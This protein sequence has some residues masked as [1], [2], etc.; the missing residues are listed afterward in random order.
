MLGNINI[1][2]GEAFAKS[3]SDMSCGKTH[4]AQISSKDFERKQFE[5]KPL[6]EF[7]F[8]ENFPNCC[9][10]HK[11]IYNIGVEKYNSFPNCCED[12]KKLNQVSWF[13]KN[14]YSYIPFKLV[15][16]LTYTWNCI[17]KCLD[18]ENWFKEI[19]DYIDYTVKSYGQFP[20]GY[21]APLG[22]DLYLHN[23]EQNINNEVE[24]PTDKKNKLVDFIKKYF[25][26]VVS[27]EQTD[28]NLLISTYKDWLKIFPFQISFL[29]HLKPAFE[30]QIP[31]LKGQG[32]TN[33]YTGLTAFNLKTKRDLIEFLISVTNSILQEI[34]TCSLFEKGILD[35]TENLKIELLVAERKTK[36]QNLNLENWKERKDYIRLLKKWFKGE[37][38]FLKEIT[39]LIKD[40]SEGA[41]IKNLVDG[42]RRLQH[43]DVNASCIVNVRENKPDK[44]T[45]F[46]YWFIDFL[47]GRYPEAII[48]AEEEKGVG[49]IDLKIVNKILGT[50]I[51]EFKGWWNQSKYNTVE[52]ICN[53][54]TEFEKVG[55]IF[56][57]N[58][59]KNKDIT[60]DYKKMIISN[61]INYIPNSFE[62]HKFKILTSI[63]LHQNTYTI[64]KRKLSIISYLMFTSKYC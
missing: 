45:S 25:S 18:N 48:T 21:G 58:H 3:L 35:E 63:I 24:I 64:Q 22:L 27:I 39:P 16:T 33:I 15:S 1:I 5:T 28:I 62:E 31:I 2:N 17:A 10:G 13:D 40:F 14:N 23:L 12:H 49:K 34:N 52:Q 37:K 26:A 54:L 51:I 43:D 42:C 59:L 19:T 9:E 38:N 47:S 36:L 57:I 50:K 6:I 29:S 60:S 30:K 46:R 7:K 53:Y 41:F 61:E 44:E 11:S 8:P 4:V 56:M 32:E 20:D 55:Y